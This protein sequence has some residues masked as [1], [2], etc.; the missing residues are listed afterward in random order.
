LRAA[1]IRGENVFAALMDAARFCLLGQT[2]H[3]LFGADGQDTAQH[4]GEGGI[5]A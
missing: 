4:V 1:G 2:G 3:A 5:T